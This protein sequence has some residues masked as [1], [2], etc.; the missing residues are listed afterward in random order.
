MMLAKE[1]E[2]D[3]SRAMRLLAA[4]G[5]VIVGRGLLRETL[6]T[7]FE[8][9]RIKVVVL[10]DARALR[11]LL[12][13]FPGG[14]V[15]ALPDTDILTVGSLVRRFC[16]HRDNIPMPDL[17]VVLEDKN[18]HVPDLEGVRLQIV[19]HARAR[20]DIAPAIFR[21]LGAGSISG[22]LEEALGVTPA[23]VPR[24]RRP[25]VGSA[26]MK[27]PVTQKRNSRRPML[28]VGLGWLAP[29]IDE[30]PGVV[31]ARVHHPDDDT[32]SAIIELRARRESDRTSTLALTG[33]LPSTRGGAVTLTSER[34]LL[35]YLRSIADQRIG[36]AAIDHRFLIDG[37]ARL[38]REWIPIAEALGVLDDVGPTRAHVEGARM[39]LTVRS[40]DEHTTGR[41][42][43]AA[44]RVWMALAQRRMGLVD[45]THHT[46]SDVD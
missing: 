22:S 32:L 11:G 3:R 30:H 16:A 43:D 21:A 9:A 38:A 20:K 18:A 26:T 19:L 1:R 33:T 44:A 40:L 6:R 27:T 8:K 36:F 39:V 24:W 25:D 42:I 45:S 15:I 29:T 14:L 5:V 28:E 23:A 12:A 13:A 10:D 41:A 46:V 7:T 31:V 2:A 35:G 34:G 17:I 4:H 37:D